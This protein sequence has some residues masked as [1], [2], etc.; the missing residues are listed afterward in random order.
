LAGCE[1]PGWREQDR[2]GLQRTL[3]AWRLAEI[4]RDGRAIV[5]L[6]QRL[7][8]QTARIAE[9]RGPSLGAQHLSPTGF[10]ALDDHAL[11]V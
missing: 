2:S 8:E 5:S 3:H 9:L 6:R 7:A 10:W 4:V 11:E 1:R